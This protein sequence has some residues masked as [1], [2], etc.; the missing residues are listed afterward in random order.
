MQNPSFKKQATGLAC[1]LILCLIS[2][3]VFAVYHLPPGTILPGFQLKG[4]DSTE[5]KTYLGINEDKPFALSQIKA[6][7]ILVEFFDVFNITCQKNTPLLNR[8]FTVLREDKNLG[9][10][11]KLIGVAL[12][13]QTKDLEVYRKSFKAEFPLFADPENEILDRVKGKI[14]FVPMLVFLDK[15]GKVLLDHP[16]AIDNFD[17]LLA[18]IRKKSKSGS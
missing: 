16:G 11:I 7:L 12:G 13:A 18:E 3:L 2:S 10:E 4:L 8:L 6:R 15:N 14:K 1:G 9:Q 5:T 17:D